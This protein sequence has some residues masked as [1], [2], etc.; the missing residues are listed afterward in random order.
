MTLYHN[1]YNANLATA[2]L[3]N[4]L[5]KTVTECHLATSPRVILQVMII[6]EDHAR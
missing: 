2:L 1:Y 3:M 5:Y 6:T 4:V